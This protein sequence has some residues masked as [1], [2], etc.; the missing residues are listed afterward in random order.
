MT[1]PVYDRATGRLYALSST[2]QSE[3]TGYWSGYLTSADAAFG[4]Q[5]SLAQIWADQGGVYLFLAETPADPAAFATALIALL[6]QLSPQGWLRFAW[7]ANPNDS[8]FAWQ[9]L[10]LDA[11]AVGAASGPWRVVRDMV[12][13]LSNYALSIRGGTTLSLATTTGAE[14]VTLTG[15][16]AFVAPEAVYPAA[17]AAGSLPLQGRHLGC[18]GFSISLSHGGTASDDME[19]LG[20]MFRYGLADAASPVGAVL[21]VDMPLF[22]QRDTTAIPLA[23]Q[24]DPLNPLLPART[25]LDFFPANSAPPAFTYAQRTNV[26]HGML[27]TP[28]SATASLPGARLAFGRTP[29]FH[30]AE[31]VG[32]SFIHHL[33]PDGLFALA[34]DPD[35]T[36]G[37]DPVR[38]I[39][40]ASGA[41]Y[42]K[43]PAGGGQLLFQ[44]AS[45]AYVPPAAPDSSPGAVERV[46]LTGLGT[47]GYAAPLPDNSG[48][49]GLT[50]YAQPLQAPLFE[51]AGAPAGF[52]SFLEM[53]A[54][55]LPGFGAE[56]TP[57]PALMPIGVYSRIAPESID[58]AALIENAALAPRRRQIVGLPTVP[59]SDP[60]QTAEIAQPMAVTPKGLAALL[61]Q[62]KLSWAG[63]LF[64]YMPNSVHTR[65]ALTA[66]SAPLQAALQSNQLFMV[67]S[68]VATF[69]SGSSVAYQLTAD[70]ALPQ[71]KSRGVPDNVAVAV[72]AVLAAQQPPYPVFSTETAFDAVVATAAGTW[73]PQ[74]QAAAG[75]LRADIEGWNF[76]LSPRSWRTDSTSPTLMLFKYCDRAITELATDPAA[77]AWSE[78]AR[79]GGGSLT[80]TLA[81]LNGILAVARLRSADPS[82]A[83][84]DPYALF[85]REVA[86]NPQWNGVLF[87]NA[88][89]DFLQMPQPL[90]FLAA[91]V[92][93]AKFYAHHI[94]FSVTPYNADSSA[95][96]LGQTAAFGLIDYNDPQDLVASTTIP[97]GFKTLQM[98]IRFANARIATFSAQ[99]ELMVNRLFG[100][101]LTKTL[102]ARGNNLI[103][104]GSYQ[105][106]G[107]APSYSFALIGDNLFQT[108]GA[109]LIGVDVRNVRLETSSTPVDGQL[110]A[111]FVLSGRLSFVAIPGFDLFS[112]G[113]S[114]DT[115][116][117]L[118]F[119]GL[120]VTMAFPLSDPLQQ[121][122]SVAESAIAFDTSSTASVA[123]PSSLA[124]NFPLQLLQ[125]VG[126]PNLADPG[127]PPKGATPGDMGFTSIGA[128]FDQTPLEP[129][130]YGL[131]F[132]LDL[133]TLGA[134]SGA[135]GL[136]ITLLAAWMQGAPGTETPPA[137][138]GL[139]LGISNALNGSLP[140]QG[141]LKLGFRS[142]QFE[143]YET[144]EG[145]LAYLLRM[146]RFALSVLI[147]SFPPGNAD[148]LLFGAPGAPKTA[149][150][151]YAAYTPEDAKKKKDAL[152]GRTASS[153]SLPSGGIRQ[154]SGRRTPPVA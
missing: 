1:A 22:R 65:V 125:L 108:N 34:P 45:A 57:P 124:E 77:W 39:L 96:V 33:T 31:A 18:I 56:H 152:G 95:L 132:N 4:D 109:A 113:P 138:L 83:P 26:G 11:T 53:P 35:E 90:Q 116:G 43:L 93:A 68:N 52:L 58:N 36:A 13:P 92:D 12:Q 61:S 29:L 102:Q 69:M 59:S 107:G 111:R 79:D 48:D 121:S 87:L 6:P 28:K 117:Y 47:T 119:S 72:K 131:A 153:P 148:L 115:P 19:R 62:D 112:Y 88:P 20:V 73:L 27:A 5:A 103:L 126:S 46:L 71:M 63:V 74:V 55:Q 99:V 80:P 9:L 154:L 98:R 40:G 105:R 110:T 144:D 94:G 104:D 75:L 81:V 150:G 76:Q 17:D 10:G 3:V 66:V 127:E 44:A 123:R 82:A 100:S 97:L 118:A 151:W 41:E 134:L 139:K 122:F 60:A 50:Y 8:A 106:V 85:Y 86:D 146:R 38:L 24:F 2:L 30:A 129:P 114:G 101:W 120:A 23:M 78:A 143:T 42:V 91:G 84:D 14:G 140:L 15:A 142:F 133:G 128:P 37:T 32:A 145:T 130:W 54:A 16:L 64:A 51:V 70:N 89:V 136:K 141:V 7:I 67:V 25:A 49:P 137:F 21:T 149:L 135:I 147:W